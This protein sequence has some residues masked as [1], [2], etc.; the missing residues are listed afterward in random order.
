MDDKITPTIVADEIT[1][2]DAV[3][4]LA[5]VMESLDRFN[6]A[7]MEIVSKTACSLSELFDVHGDVFY[8]ELYKTDYRR[9]YSEA[10]S[11]LRLQKRDNSIKIP[12]W[13]PQTMVERARESLHGEE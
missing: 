2:S 7:L 5:R 3:A 9:Q 13:I 8:A 12:E 4:Q 11:F 1:G 6:Q 10:R